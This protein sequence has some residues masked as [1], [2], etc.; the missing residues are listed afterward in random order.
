M[1]MVKKVIKDIRVVEIMSRDVVTIA[2][3]A[4]LK[5]AHEIFRKY[6]YNALPVVSGGRVVGIMT[7]LDLLRAFSFGTKFR[8][9]NFWD[10]LSEKVSDVMRTAVVSV[11]PNDKLQTVVD[12]M[13]EFSLRSIPVIENDRVVGMVSREDIMSHLA[14]ED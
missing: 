13:V 4:T 11:S 9:S 5:D 7:K 2:P 10:T 1:L 6:D 12:H 8:R 14:L 3:E